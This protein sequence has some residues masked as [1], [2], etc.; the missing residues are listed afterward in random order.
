M[1]S[2]MSLAALSLMDYPGIDKLEVAI[3]TPKRSIEKWKM[4]GEK[5]TM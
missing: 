5:K 3:N 1:H 4:E 2:Y